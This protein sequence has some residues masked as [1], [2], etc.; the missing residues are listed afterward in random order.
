MAAC[1]L[2]LIFRKKHLKIIELIKYSATLSVTLTF[3][4]V[5]LVLMPLGDFN[6]QFYLI[7]DGA[8]FRHILCPLLAIISFLFFEN[9]SLEN[10]LKNNLRAVYFT[11]I[12]TVIMAILNILRIIV[13][14]YP[15]LEVYNQSV[16]MSVIWI[17]VIL[18]L[19]LVLARILLY[20]KNRISYREAQN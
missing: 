15:F 11:I 4:M 10:S 9:T 17:I 18:G 14:P 19:D 8:F 16:L 1:I 2:Y 6:Y 13:G 12:Y 20:V 7:D 3:L 5:L